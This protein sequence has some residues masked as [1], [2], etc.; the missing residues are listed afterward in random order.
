MTKVLEA[1]FL[2]CML[3]FI[4]WQTA[5]ADEPWVYFYDCDG[6]GITD[7]YCNYQVSTPLSGCKYMGKDLALFSHHHYPLCSFC[8]GDQPQHCVLVKLGNS[9]LQ[10]RHYTFLITDQVYCE[11][12][13][14]DPF[15]Y[16]PF[17]ILT[18]RIRTIRFL[19]RFR[20]GGRS[21]GHC[22]VCDR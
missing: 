19:A 10:A 11:S 12:F 5:V 4:P 17:Q 6:N 21:G 22:S 14:G 20:A 9:T 7:C 2:L 16:S 15:K 13:P 8:C 1:A 18:V 3:I